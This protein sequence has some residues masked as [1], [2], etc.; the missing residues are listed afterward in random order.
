MTIQAAAGVTKS[1]ETY[2]NT[3]DFTQAC[4]QPFTPVFGDLNGDGFPDLTLGCVDGNVPLYLNDGKGNFTYSKGLVESVVSDFMQ[5]IIA[6]LNGDGIPDIAVL[7]NFDV[8]VFF[9][10]GGLNFTAPIY[11][12]TGTFPA[13]MLEMNLHGQTPQDGTPDLV[14]PDSSQGKV[15]S[16]LNLTK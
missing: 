9:G 13:Y 10:K 15:L 3:Q 7:T 14:V 6:D 16:I 12:G 1:K 2:F 4:I 11:L 8:A 5:P